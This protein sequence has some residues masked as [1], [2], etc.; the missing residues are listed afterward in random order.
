MKMKVSELQGAALDIWV[1]RAQGETYARVVGIHESERVEVR[2]NAVSAWTRFA[3]SSNWAQGGP[4]IEREG[5]GVAKFYEPADGHI[6]DGGE[7]GA[8]TLDDEIRSDGP[9]PLVAAMRLY[10]MVHFGEVVSE[11]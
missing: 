8:L 3:P 2:P 4:I 5:F 6:P 7:W 10:V 9:T 1:A 11:E